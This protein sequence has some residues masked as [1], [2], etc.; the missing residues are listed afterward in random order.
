[1]EA[2]TRN[3]AIAAIVSLTLIAALA[4]MAYENQLKDEVGSTG[5]PIY[6]WTYD[7]TLTHQ[8]YQLLGSMPIG[9]EHRVYAES[10]TLNDLRIHVAVFSGVV[11]PQ[12]IY[13]KIAEGYYYPESQTFDWTWRYSPTNL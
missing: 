10:V 9:I 8:Y 11:S 13:K 5:L 12:A 6:G 7:R 2:N 1:M 4:T 3:A